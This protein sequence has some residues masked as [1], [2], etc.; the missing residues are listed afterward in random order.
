MLVLEFKVLRMLSGV[1]LIAAVPGGC[2]GQVH[3][4][5]AVR[6]HR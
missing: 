4:G 3:D 6:H 5:T 1:S 2:K